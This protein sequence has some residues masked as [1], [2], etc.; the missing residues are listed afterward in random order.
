MNSTSR[1]KLIS[2][3][4]HHELR[5]RFAFVEKDHHQRKRLFFDNS[6]GSFRLKTADEKLKEIDLICDCPER[7][8]DIAKELIEIIEEGKKNIGK[9][10]GSNQGTSF[11]RYTASLC[12]Y[13]LINLAIEQI[14][15]K[16]VVTTILEHPSSYDACEV[17]CKKYGKELRVAGVNPKTGEIKVDE[18]LSLVDDQTSLVNLI[19]ASNITGSILDL[20]KLIPQIREKNKDVYIMSDAVQ[21]APHHLINFDE[22]GLDACTLALYKMFGPRGIGI[23]WVSDRF[24]K[25]IHPKL[26]GKDDKDWS[27]GSPSPGFY[28]AITEVVHYIEWLGRKEGEDLSGK[29]EF[30][31]GMQ[32]IFNHEKAL[33]NFLLE[34]CE[35][36]RG[37]KSIPGV[38]LHFLDNGIDHRDLIVALSIEGQSPQETVEHYARHHVTVYER[39]KE[40]I[41]SKRMIEA[42]E[43]EGVVRI[44]PIHVH[45]QSE[46]EEFLKITEFIAKGSK[47]EA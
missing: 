44:S 47:L 3:E 35:G 37:L 22:I 2:H 11:L 10:V 40:S 21:H 29:N 43:L 12:N 13:E 46:M 23:G 6:G 19:Y 42:L 25:L 15:G 39:V 30:E 1:G 16:N 27:L 8:H 20:G 45:N 32:V 41:Y 31:K 9:I 36:Q 5:S 17:A 7:K 38:H 34:G 33:L 28:Q 24:S 14:P 4:V 18:I 26:L